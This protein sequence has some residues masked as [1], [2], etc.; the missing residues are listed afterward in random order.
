[1]I[2]WFGITLLILTGSWSCSSGEPVQSFQPLKGTILV[3]S[4]ALSAD[5]VN[6]AK[7][8]R[9]LGRFAR[10]DPFR[11][12]LWVTNAD[13]VAIS[14]GTTT[15]PGLQVIF[16]DSTTA[17]IEKFLNR[18]TPPG[19][20]FTVVVSPFDW[21]RT[22][23]LHQSKPGPHGALWI[24]TQAEFQREALQVGGDVIVSPGRERRYLYKLTLNITQA[25]LPLTDISRDWFQQEQLVHT[26]SRDSRGKY[27]EQPVVSWAPTP[28]LL[29]F[30]RSMEQQ[31]DSLRNVIATTPNTVLMDII[32]F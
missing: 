7:R 6:P 28:G 24:C 27:P 5:A 21:K 22:V 19:K 29:T 2:K 10:S 3:Q 14:P 18:T 25:D 11:Q 1:M 17:G 15:I 9:H 4:R 31:I 26:L 20:A 8:A 13:T 12:L 30:Y 16:I 32:P 23:Q